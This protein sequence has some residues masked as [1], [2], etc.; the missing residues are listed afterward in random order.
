[1]I[2][3]GNLTIG[4]LVVAAFVLITLLFTLRKMV[5]IVQQGEV[6]VVKRLGEY[7]KTHEPGLVIVAP[8]IDGAA[9]CRH[10][11]DPGSRRPP[12]GD[13]QRQR[14][15]HGQRDDLH[16]DRRC[17][18]GVVQRCQL[19]RGHRRARSNRAA[20]GHRHALPRRGPVG[21]RADQHRC[22]VADGSRHRQVGHPHRSHRDRRDQPPPKILEALALQKQADQEKRAKILQSE[23]NQQSAI[24]IADGAGEGCHPR[25]RGR[26]RSRH[27]PR[28]RQPAGLH[29]RS[30]RPSPGDRQ[31]LQRDPY[32][33]PRPVAH[34][35]P[36][37]R[38]TVPSSPT[39]T[40]PRSSCRSRAQR[41]SVPPRLFAPC[42][43]EFPPRRPRR[44][45]RRTSVPERRLCRSGRPHRSSAWRATPLEDRSRRRRSLRV[46]QRAGDHVAAGR[47]DARAAASE[48]LHA[49]G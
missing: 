46:V 19:R 15:R 5:N 42:S 2:A 39:A 1:M 29:P 35:D 7:R 17:Q 22:A 44:D 48:H 20:I 41:C 47:H 18:A 3:L 6:G 38:H 43:T 12:R 11:R 14:R 8:F 49:F 45:V 34:R 16:P 9:T 28:R 36:A 24:N 13:H 32:R 26:T 21:T 23:G 31:R 10:P 40:T 27:P 25:C 4:A 30:G 33:Q 37:A